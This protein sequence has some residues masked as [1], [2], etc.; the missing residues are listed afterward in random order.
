[1]KLETQPVASRT[2]IFTDMKGKAM[3]TLDTEARTI[4]VA[5]GV[6]VSEA[7]QA[8][9]ERLTEHLGWPAPKVEEKKDAVQQNS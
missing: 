6:S 4:T 8:V 5:E 2:I 9:L 1:M 7:A 3:L